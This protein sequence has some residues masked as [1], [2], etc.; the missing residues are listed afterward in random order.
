MKTWYVAM[1]FKE[2]WWFN[3]C[4]MFCWRKCKFLCSVFQKNIWNSH[5]LDYTLHL[6]GEIRIYIYWLYLWGILYVVNWFFSI[7]YDSQTI[8]VSYCFFLNI[9]LV[10]TWINI[11]GFLNFVTTKF[12]LTIRPWKVLS[13][14]KKRFVQLNT[15][16]F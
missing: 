2:S 9:K 3:A 13:H 5:P 6:S 11:G 10:F 12:C 16:H 4:C 14:Q 8:I 1:E 15:V 7:M